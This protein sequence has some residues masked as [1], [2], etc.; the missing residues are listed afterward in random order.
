MMP[1][2]VVLMVL[3]VAFSPTI[4]T[5]S[6]SLAD[7]VV[8]KESCGYYGHDNWNLT[9]KVKRNTFNTD[10]EFAEIESITVCASFNNRGGFNAPATIVHN[11]K[12]GEQYKPT[13]MFDTVK[14]R[15]DDTAN[16][17]AWVGTGS[18]RGPGWTMRGELRLDNPNNPLSGTYTEALWEG[19]RLIG[20]IL[21]TCTELSV[22]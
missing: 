5:V 1:N 18:R 4:L 8:Y 20:E 12:K 9:C 13:D 14:F 2:N 16:N 7:A 3:G 15:G 10:Y 17:I 6:N 11:Y 21:S 19:R 22:D